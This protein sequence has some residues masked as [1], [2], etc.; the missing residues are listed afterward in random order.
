MTEA[1]FARAQQDIKTLGER[2]GNSTL[3]K[4]YA[5]GEYVALVGTL[6][7]E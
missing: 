6:L 1:S 2:P 3:L 4:L 5:Q 7:S